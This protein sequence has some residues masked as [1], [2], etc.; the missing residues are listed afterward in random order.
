MDESDKIHQNWLESMLGQKQEHFDLYTLA[1]KINSALEPS[2]NKANEIILAAGDNRGRIKS[3]SKKFHDLSNKYHLE[4]DLVIGESLSEDELAKKFLINDGESDYL[5]IN[6]QLYIE[7]K[8]DPFSLAGAKG[9]LF[10]NVLEK[11]KSSKQAI[12]LDR[13][14]EDLNQNIS[15]FVRNSY[16]MAK[17]VQ[18]RIKDQSPP[19]SKWQ[20]EIQR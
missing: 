17:N 15:S 1:K 3:A 10:V 16:S 20:K 18:S 7:Y 11:K 9:K 2:F 12:R 19:G 13:M 8:P 5:N 14:L 6:D 4:A